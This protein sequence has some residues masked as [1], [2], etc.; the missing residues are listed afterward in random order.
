MTDRIE[1][2]G[3]VAGVGDVLEGFCMKD[4]KN[5]EQSVS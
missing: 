3:E 4:W 5:E 1:I 2:S